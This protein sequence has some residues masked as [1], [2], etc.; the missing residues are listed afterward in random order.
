MRRVPPIAWG[1]DRRA[2]GGVR[3]RAFGVVV[4]VATMALVGFSVSARPGRGDLSPSARAARGAW[5]TARAFSRVD[6]TTPGIPTP[7]TGLGAWNNGGFDGVDGQSSE[8]GTGVAWSRAA[9]DFHLLPGALHRVSYVEALALSNRTS[10]RVRAEVY[11]DCDGRP[12]VLLYAAEGQG[13]DS[14]ADALGLNVLRVGVATPGLSLE[15]G[16]AYWL[17]VVG[18]GDGSGTDHFFWCTAGSGVIQG[19]SGHVKA[20]VFW[21]NDWTP[22]AAT[23]IGK[24]DFAFTVHGDEC[25]TLR[26]N[27][28]PDVSQAPAPALNVAG[29]TARIADDFVTPACDTWVLECVRLCVLTNCDIA[30]AVVEVYDTDP[31]TMGPGRR[32]A[33]LQ[34]PVARAVESVHGL[35]RYELEFPAMTRLNGGGRYWIALSGPGT[36]GARDRAYFC[37]S[38]PCATGCDVFGGQARVL[39]AP[40]TSWRPIEAVLGEPRDLSFSVHGYRAVGRLDPLVAPTHGLSSKPGR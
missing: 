29:P 2:G 10:A 3:R 27:G 21:F 32:L 17:S 19:A 4:A 9:D 7:L 39:D 1:R 20:P 14:G 36:G 25:P 12:G 23:N 26:D 8:E 13:M 31:L 22:T 18:L 40:F 30:R 11:D 5:A 28:G 38:D 6:W 33:T 35:T 37:L 15:G 24:S 34:T 16:R